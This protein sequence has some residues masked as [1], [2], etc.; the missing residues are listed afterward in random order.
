MGIINKIR[1]LLGLKPVKTADEMFKDLG[2]EK[3]VDF[4]HI[5]ISYRKQIDDNIT[6]VCVF[7]LRD[8]SYSVYD[9]YY[10]EAFLS[11]GLYK[12]EYESFRINMD[13]HKAINKQIEEL[14][15]DSVKNK[16]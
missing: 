2:F 10:N 6:R 14:G 9:F 3:D 16:R 11:K 15:W 8:K 5:S 7:Y 12:P 4:L 13:L 1:K